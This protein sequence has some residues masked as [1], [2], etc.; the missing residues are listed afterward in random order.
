MREWRKCQRSRTDVTVLKNANG[1]PHSSSYILSWAISKSRYTLEEIAGA[2]DASVELL[3][4][5][6][7]SK[8]KSTTQIRKLSAK[9]H[10][11][12]AA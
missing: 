3:N 2:V 10:R 9:L 4:I 1:P 11:S 6:R 12:C 7:S 5:W 8:A